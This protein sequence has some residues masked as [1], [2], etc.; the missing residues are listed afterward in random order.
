MKK[1][2]SFSKRKVIFI[3]ISPYLIVVLGLLSY[4]LIDNVSISLNGFRHPTLKNYI[5]TITDPLFLTVNLNTLIWVVSCV[6]LQLFF[7]GII[8]LLLNVDFKGNTIFR[9]IILVLPWATPDVVAAVAWKWMYNDMYGVLND[10]L[11]KLGILKAYLPWLGDIGLAK[12]AVIIAN[13]WKGFAVSS[14]IYLAG[15]KTIPRQ[16]YEAAE[17]DGAS[18]WK[19]LLWITFPSMRPLILTTVLLTVMWTFNYFPLIYIMTGGGPSNATDTIVTYS[20]R[21]AFWLLDFG[22]AA[23]LSTVAFLILLVIAIVYT[24]FLIKEK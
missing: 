19:K 12:V 13:V 6:V 1:K 4:L 8:A 24:T 10:V 3:Y 23:S 2:V 5:S 9:I 15:L 16:L 11:C 20:Y 14:M 7:A 21:Q 22:K 17:I 18:V